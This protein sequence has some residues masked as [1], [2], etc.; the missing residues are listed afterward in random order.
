[1]NA[2]IR[3]IAPALLFAGSMWLVVSAYQEDE[4]SQH[5]SV[6]E[7]SSSEAIVR[8]QHAQLVVEELQSGPK[9]VAELAKNCD[10]TES[11]VRQALEILKSKDAVYLTDDG[12][13][14]SKYA[15]D[16]SK[17]GKIALIR[18]IGMRFV[19]SP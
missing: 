4:I 6:E 17:F 11:R 7:T 3:S 16:E 8:L 10:L 13:R 14:D 15:V 9:T 19:R 18:S 1:M 2:G 12:S 5:I